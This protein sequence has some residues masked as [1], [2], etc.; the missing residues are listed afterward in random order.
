MTEAA[1]S[2]LR[3]PATALVVCGVLGILAAMI[4]A[5]FNLAMLAGLM[6]D[7]WVPGWMNAAFLVFDA[8]L[9]CLY[10]WQVWAAL[11]LRRLELGKNAAFA[12]AIIALLPC[13]SCFCITVGLGIWAMIVL[14]RAEVQEELPS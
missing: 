3:G 6:E 10:G 2:A 14:T 9:F 13:Q 5:G 12:A 7:A 11:R 8:F 4:D 1:R